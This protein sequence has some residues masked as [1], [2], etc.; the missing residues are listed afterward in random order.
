MDVPDP[1]YIYRMLTPED[2]E[3]AE[4]CQWEILADYFREMLPIIDRPLP[5][6]NRSGQEDN[7]TEA[8]DE[9]VAPPS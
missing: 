8:P 7:D 3:W 2:E 9:A 1:E 4:E 5:E 6:E